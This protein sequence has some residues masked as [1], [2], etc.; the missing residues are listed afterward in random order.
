MT[1]PSPEFS[2]Q[3]VL[4]E[5][6]AKV[7]RPD[8]ATLEDFIRRFPHFSAEIT[9]FAVEWILQDELA[10]DGSDGRERP[11]RSAVPEAMRRARARLDAIGPVDALDLRPPVADPFADRSPTDLRHIAADL[12]LDKTL[13]AK[14]RDRKIVAE[15]IPS[16]LREALAARLEVPL[17]VVVAHLAAPAS[18][19]RSAS[20]KSTGKPE[21]GPKET[22]AEAVRRS[23]LPEADRNHWLTSPRS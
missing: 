14:L 18:I 1:Q 8:A 21:A 3:D 23:A 17:P 19:H 9:D 15:T 20:F 5:L 7:D 10:T 13:I 4:Q 16:G 11:D 2:L 22:F 12:G 6:V